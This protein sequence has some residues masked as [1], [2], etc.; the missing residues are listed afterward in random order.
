MFDRKVDPLE[1][2]D[3]SEMTAEELAEAIR[4]ARARVIAV[5]GGGPESGDDED[6]VFG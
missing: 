5:E 3:P 6:D 4:E 1:Q 2:R